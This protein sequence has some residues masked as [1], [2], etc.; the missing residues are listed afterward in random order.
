MA[1]QHGDAPTG[2]S[3]PIGADSGFLQQVN[4]E[5]GNLGSDGSQSFD[6]TSAPP[7]AETSIPA[8]VAPV[9]AAA[10]STSTSTHP[11]AP[12]PAP[13]PAAVNGTQVKASNAT[14]AAPGRASVAPQGITGPV[15]DIIDQMAN[16][17]VANGGKVRLTNY[18]SGHRQVPI[19]VWSARLTLYTL[20][21]V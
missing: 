13:A 15:K 10:A 18:V 7:A 1:E 19:L 2:F 17:G 11:A 12:V 3:A 4:T 9:P 6:T 14:H 5:Q 16:A 21:C 8:G 20:L